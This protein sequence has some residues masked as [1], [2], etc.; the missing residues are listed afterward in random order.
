MEHEIHALFFLREYLIYGIIELTLITESERIMRNKNA[1]GI[2]VVLGFLTIM[3][4]GSYY[5]FNN[6]PDTNSI[7]E[8]S[9]VETKYSSQAPIASTSSTQTDTTNTTSA[10]VILPAGVQEADKVGNMAYMVNAGQSTLDASIKSAP[11]VKFSQLDELQRPQVANAWLNNTTRIYQDRNSTGN[12]AKIEPVG[13]H[14]TK[15]G[16]TWLYNR[17]HLLGYALIGGLKNVDASE[18][19]KLNIVTQTASVN[20]GNSATDNGQNY[21]EGL[22]RQALDKHKNVRYQVKPYYLQRELVPRGVFMQAKSSDNSLNYNVYI[23]NVQSGATIDY[24]TGYAH[25][26]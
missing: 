19:N 8:E 13:Y 25:A 22:V 12:T 15:I 18:G 7:H 11:W 26:S 6:A 14:Q 20:Q 24:E 10:G 2:A 23:P 1:T 5:E 4:G 3:L 21:Y 17:G 16:N 9:H